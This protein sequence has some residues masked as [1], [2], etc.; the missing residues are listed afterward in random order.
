MEH[1]KLIMMTL[2]F[3]NLESVFIRPC[4]IASF[5][6]DNIVE[7]KVK[8][9]YSDTVSSNKIASA[10]IVLNNSA[11]EQLQNGS[12]VFERLAKYN[13]ITIIDLKYDDGSTE[14]IYVEW[15]D[16]EYSNEYQTYTIAEQGYFVITI[17]KNTTAKE[18]VARIFNY[19]D[20]K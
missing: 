5:L 1:K 15:G 2:F 17:N 20:K 11:N 6:I 13:D 12:T 3:E 7:R 10:T 4:N 19:N 16:G 18:E 14:E 8:S 9:W